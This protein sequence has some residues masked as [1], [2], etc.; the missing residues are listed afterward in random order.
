LCLIES[1]YNELV[2][3]GACCS[4]AVPQ[5]SAGPL[6][7]VKGELFL[8]LKRIYRPSLPTYIMLGFYWVFVFAFFLYYYI[9]E[10]NSPFYVIQAS[11]LLVLFIIWMRT[12]YIE[13]TPDGIA[14][15]FAFGYKKSITWPEIAQV[16][17]V[18]SKEGPKD[19]LVIISIKNVDSSKKD[20]KINVL[21]FKQS[22]I[23]EF[24]EVLIKNVPNINCDE[25]VKE[26]ASGIIP[27][28][29]R[30]KKKS[31]GLTSNSS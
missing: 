20:I 13:V 8:D 3:L 19:N 30:R 2:S 27:S 25:T 16:S 7:R 10:S 24:A 1:W 26:Y 6:A 29:F 11:V 5:L 18:A 4:F 28:W 31:R 14:Y 15:Y 17:V 12:L 21:K 9:T 22:D 23:R